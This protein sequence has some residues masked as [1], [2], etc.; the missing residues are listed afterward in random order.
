M[1]ISP[2][3]SQLEPSPT[4]SDDARGSHRELIHHALTRDRSQALDGAA[5]LLVDANAVPQPR[6]SRATLERAVESLPDRR[7]TKLDT[8]SEAKRRRA[9][10]IESD[11][12]DLDGGFEVARRQL[13]DGQSPMVAMSSRNMFS[14]TF[15]RGTRGAQQGVATVESATRPAPEAATAAAPAPAT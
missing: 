2:G 15:A 5:W 12:D 6:I 14:V 11:I 1:G 7:L 9:R 10:E 8:E 3:K 13:E 4:S